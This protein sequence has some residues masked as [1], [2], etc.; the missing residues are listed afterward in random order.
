MLENALNPLCA[1]TVKRMAT[2]YLRVLRTHALREGRLNTVKA[3]SNTSSG[4]GTSS[5]LV[6]NFM[7]HRHFIH[8]PFYT[9]ASHS[10]ILK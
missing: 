5:I 10:F 2:I 8:L 9:G 1:A 7:I 3:P 4:Q 6:G